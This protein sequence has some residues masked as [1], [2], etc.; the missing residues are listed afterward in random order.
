MTLELLVPLE[1][2]MQLEWDKIAVVL[3]AKE[4]SRLVCLRDGQG[5]LKGT[6]GQQVAK[7]TWSRAL[8]QLNP[9]QNFF[10]DQGTPNAVCTNATRPVSSKTSTA[11]TARHTRTE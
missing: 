11:S 3:N 10:H 4:A 9:P 8:P 2:R 1:H 6:E 7:S 5:L